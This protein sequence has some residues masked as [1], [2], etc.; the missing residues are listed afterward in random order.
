MTPVPRNAHMLGSGTT[1]PTEEDCGSVAS[2]SI[3]PT[4]RIFLVVERDGLL[5]QFQRVLGVEHDG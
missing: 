5:G 1:V 2:R 3:Q 4:Q